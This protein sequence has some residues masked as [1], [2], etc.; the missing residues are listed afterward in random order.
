MT[1][2]DNIPPPPPEDDPSDQPRRGN[3]TFMTPRRQ[4][5]RDVWAATRWSV[6][7]WEYRDIAAAMGISVSTA[8]HRVTRGLRIIE[9]P[10]IAAAE[11]A[12]AIHRARLEAAT[13]VAMD[14]MSRDHHHVSQG[15]VMTGT[16]GKPLIDDA[17]KLAAAGKVKELSESLRKLDGLDAPSKVEHSGDMTYQIVGVNPDDLA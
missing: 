9:A 4:R 7:G 14:V 6:D 16:D 15:R 10:T 17:P 11:Q 5:A 13:E 1:D 3:H 8:W 12:R 2:P